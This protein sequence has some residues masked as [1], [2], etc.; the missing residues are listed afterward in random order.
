[1]KHANKIVGLTFLFIGIIFII[2]GGLMIYGLMLVSSFI[3]ALNAFPGG[4]AVTGSLDTILTFSWVMAVITLI[5][6]ILCII[7]AVLH[8][9]Y[10]G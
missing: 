7:S 8:F 4:A 3:G 1:M 10:K 2:Y 9:I 5:T 6:G